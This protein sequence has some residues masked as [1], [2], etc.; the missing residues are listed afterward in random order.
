MVLRMHSVF[1]GWEEA[2]RILSKILHINQTAVCIRVYKSDTR[3]SGLGTK[4]S[5]LE[6]KRHMSITTLRFCHSHP[7]S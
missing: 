1:V 7:K 6:I 5:K 2:R 3:I 4:L